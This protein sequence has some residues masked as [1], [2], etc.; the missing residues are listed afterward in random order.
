MSGSNLTKA[1]RALCVM[2]GIVSAPPAA[3]Q[4]APPIRLASAYSADTFHTV[5]LVEFAKD[6]RDGTGGRVSIDVRPN[7]E[8][9]KAAD[10]LAG[11]ADGRAEAGELIMSSMSQEFPVMG[12]DSFPFIVSGYVDAKALWAASRPIAAQALAK[13]DIKLLFAVPWPPQNLYSSRAIDRPEDFSGLRMRF[14]NPATKRIAE[15]IGA[16]PVTVP[17]QMAAIEKAIAAGEF[18]LMITSSSTGITTKAWTRMTHYYQLNAWIPKNAVFIRND[19]FDR[20]ADKDKKALL[21]AAQ[22][23][24]SRGWQESE[25]L[26][27]EYETQLG[28]N[29][30]VI[31]G[32]GPVVRR[33]LDRAGEKLAR[34]WMARAQP[35]ELRV[36]STYMIERIPRATSPSITIAPT[37]KRQ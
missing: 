24:E 7:A 13:R 32:T 26:N 11:V 28:K 2:V 1:M 23:A 14:Y 19:A 8:L 30:M 21:D 20:L 33:F 36:L 29:K 5:N 27:A 15:L 9:L 10:I 17:I 12:I 6:V 25:R 35:D 34:E 3:S 31:T 37:N 4:A 18:D 22:R 16:T